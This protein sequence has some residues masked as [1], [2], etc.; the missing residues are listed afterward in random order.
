MICRNNFC[1][2][3]V[4]ATYTQPDEIALYSMDTMLETFLS[5]ILP[6]RFRDFSVKMF[7]SLDILEEL[8]DASTFT[9]VPV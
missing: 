5:S 9:S 6:E 4:E 8:N 1:I 7:T 2:I 3:S